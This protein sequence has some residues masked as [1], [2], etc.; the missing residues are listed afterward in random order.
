MEEETCQVC[1]SS[2]VRIEG[3]GG[4]CIMCHAERYQDLDGRIFYTDVGVIQELERDPEGKIEG[5]IG[6]FESE[7]EE[8]GKG[9]DS[10]NIESNTDV[11]EDSM[12]PEG[13]GEHDDGPEGQDNSDNDPECEVCEDTGIDPCDEKL[14]CPVCNGGTGEKGEEKDS[15]DS[16]DP[17]AP[18]ENECP[19]CEGSGD[20]RV[21]GDEDCPY[22]D[23][24]GELPE[25]E[26]NKEGKGGE[27]EDQIGGED[28]EQEGDGEG[29]NDDDEISPMEQ[30]LE[31]DEDPFPDPID[32][33]I[34]GLIETTTL[35]LATEW[36]MNVTEMRDGKPYKK[37]LATNHMNRVKAGK[38]ARITEIP[39]FCLKVVHMSAECAG[40]VLEGNP[41]DKEN[42]ENP[43]SKLNELWEKLNKRNPKFEIKQKG[44]GIKFIKGEDIPL[45]NITLDPIS[46]IAQYKITKDFTDENS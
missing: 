14:N 17:D 25:N 7:V 6:D 26:N 43:E 38:K 35:K 24:T 30:P 23:G 29:E 1:G 33:R 2:A 11:D 20:D 31:D 8:A 9:N 42:N 21:D 10:G 34:I 28:D 4:E 46:G 27:S 16:P 12:E 37:T 18:P 36:L 45:E 22:C 44:E 5:D 39:P 3:S 13:E 15:E 32:V 41:Y 19:M 40:V